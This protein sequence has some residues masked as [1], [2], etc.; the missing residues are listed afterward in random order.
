MSPCVVCL[1][2]PA[3]RLV[4]EDLCKE[5]EAAWFADEDAPSM[6]AWAA[7]RAREFE[8]E[9]IAVVLEATAARFRELAQRN[10]FD[11][12]LVGRYEFSAEAL[13]EEA[14]AIRARGKT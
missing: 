10:D 8:R 9:A 14:A 3:L 5:C 11:S 2:E 12:S 1:R 4:A 6:V 13:G 7:Q